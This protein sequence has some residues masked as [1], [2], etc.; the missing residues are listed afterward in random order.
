MVVSLAD[1]LAEEALINEDSVKSKVSKSHSV[2]SIAYIT[3]YFD[4]ET[5][6]KQGYNDYITT[7]WMQSGLSYS[8]LRINQY[9]TLQ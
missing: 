9:V 5:S 2:V 1:K 7:R 6:M 3:Q 8:S 4:P